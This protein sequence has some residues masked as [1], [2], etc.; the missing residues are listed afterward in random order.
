MNHHLN[1]LT[2]LLPIGPLNKIKPHQT[3][4]DNNMSRVSNGLEQSVPGR[5]F[6]H[7]RWPNPGIYIYIYLKTFLQDL[8]TSLMLSIATS[9][10]KLYTRNTY[11][12]TCPPF[13]TKSQ[14]YKTPQQ[15]YIGFH[16]FI[17]FAFQL[18]SGCI[19]YLHA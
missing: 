18:C 15:A 16:L 10:L 4:P 13:G 1:L 7:L 3:E 14:T 17:Y 2:C 11:F 12:Q 9:S 19:P 8:A 6:H 5:C